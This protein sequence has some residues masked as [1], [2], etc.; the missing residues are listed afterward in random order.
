MDRIELV[1]RVL[2][3]DDLV[4]KPDPAVRLDVSRSRTLT[5]TLHP[6]KRGAADQ[7]DLQDLR[8]F[9]MRPHVL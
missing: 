6:I 3:P 1:N 4:F 2:P 9:S 7:D 8:F 5:V